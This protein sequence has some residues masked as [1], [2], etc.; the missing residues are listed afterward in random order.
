VIF[1]SIAKHFDF[2]PS[3]A[4]AVTELGVTATARHVIAAGNSL[5]INLQQHRLTT[6][7]QM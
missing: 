5:D 3:P 7:K 6:D 1:Q 2:E 4:A